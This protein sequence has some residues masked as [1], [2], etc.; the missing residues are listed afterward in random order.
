MQKGKKLPNSHT[1]EDFLPSENFRKL[2]VLTVSFI[3][4]TPIHFCLRSLHHSQHLHLTHRH[5][6]RYLHP[7]KIL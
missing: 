6:P 5:F 2:K 1:I 4:A 3:K 7:S